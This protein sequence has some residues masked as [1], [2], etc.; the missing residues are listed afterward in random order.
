MA[1]GIDIQWRVY[2]YAPEQTR[3]WVNG[4]VFAKEF[5]DL[6]TGIGNTVIT[7]GGKAAEDIII[8]KVRELR[9]RRRKVTFGFFGVNGS[10]QYYY[11][12]QLEAYDDD[13]QGKLRIYKEWKRYCKER[14]CDLQTHKITSGEFTPYGMKNTEVKQ[15]SD[16]VDLKRP[17]KIKWKESEVF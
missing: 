3:V 8:R 9:N 1:K 17:M 6:A 10:L 13:L 7:K 2:K 4:K 16:I 11:T 12:R 5:S 15:S 14:N